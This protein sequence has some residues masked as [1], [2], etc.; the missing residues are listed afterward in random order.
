MKLTPFSINVGDI[1]AQ[2]TDFVKPKFSSLRKKV[3]P[4]AS[5]LPVSDWMWYN[6]GKS[7]CGWLFSR[8]KGRPTKMSSAHGAVNVPSV[9]SVRLSPAK[10]DSTRSVYSAVSVSGMVAVTA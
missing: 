9:F 3:Y 4:S 7:G 2:R 1:V 6:G 5:L 8:A 10:Q